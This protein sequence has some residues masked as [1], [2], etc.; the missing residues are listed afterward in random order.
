VHAS[1]KFKKITISALACFFLGSFNQVVF[2]R[3]GD[4][5]NVSPSTNAV[6]MASP[7]S[8]QIALTVP[9]MPGSGCETTTPG[10]YCGSPQTTTTL[11]MF[12][13]PAK[14]GVLCPGQYY[15]Y[16]VG[17]SL[18]SGGSCGGS[19][20]GNWSGLTLVN[21]GSGSNV[22]ASNN[23]YWIG[24]GYISPS[25][26]N[27][28]ENVAAMYYLQPFTI[29]TNNQNAFYFNTESTMEGGGFIDYCIMAVY[30]TKAYN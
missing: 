4:S 22:S 14:G 2:A 1:N 29:D 27:P 9:F 30:Q 17:C 8:C 25:H 16:F 13:S 5:S 11:N 19:S 24:N 28:G 20:C 18:Y 26:W 15:A 23:V 21:N 12:N 10:Q 7:N 6:I 3:A